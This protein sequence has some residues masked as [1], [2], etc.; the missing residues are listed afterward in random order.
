MIRAMLTC[1]TATFAAGGCAAQT[2]QAAPDP[3]HS[4]LVMLRAAPDHF[5]PGGNYGGSYGDPASRAARTRIARRIADAHKLRIAGDWPMPM[6]GIDCFVM[7]VPDARTP[8]QASTE[9]AHEAGVAWSQPVALFHGQAVPALKPDP[10]QPAQPAERRWR[11]DALHRIATGKG[12]SIAVIDSRIEARHPDLA[13]QMNVARDFAE[14]HGNAA[15]RHGTGVAGVI[16]ARG[17]NGVGIIGIAP[18]ARL[19]GLRACW[20]NGGP[21]AGAATLCDSLSLAKAMHFALEHRAQIINLSLTGPRDMLLGKLI[22]LGI[23]NGAT[24]VA[25]VDPQQAD[26]GFPASQRGVIAVA[27]QPMA[28]RGFPVYI[29]P[30]RDIPTTAPGGTWLLVNGSSFAAAHVSGLMAL[31]RERTAG[32]GALTLRSNGGEIDACR[33]ILCQSTT[34]DRGCASLCPPG[35]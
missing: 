18:E 1:L 33:T 31:A 2:A 10:L 8:E 32:T 19:M 13:G 7:L 35:R 34:R 28:S 29:A 27:A 11:L 24:I 25:A 6:L 16:A 20:D 4:I 5:R 12:V 3:Q 26:G 23:A 9:V 21:S 14:G 22:E 15:E 30:G 17:G